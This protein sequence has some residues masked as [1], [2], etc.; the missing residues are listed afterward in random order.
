M[1]KFLEAV[2]RANITIDRENLDIINWIKDL[3]SKNIE[4]VKQAK[5]N[6]SNPDWQ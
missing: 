6:E 1:R 2:D 3:E 4:W 5:K